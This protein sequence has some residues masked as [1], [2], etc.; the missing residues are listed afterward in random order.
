M[1]IVD[2][3]QKKKKKRWWVKCFKIYIF[4]KVKNYITPEE[5]IEDYFK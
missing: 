3:V 4:E 5:L 1:A 2:K